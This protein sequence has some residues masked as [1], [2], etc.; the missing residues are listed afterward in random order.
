MKIV[1]IVSEIGWAL[2]RLAVQRVSIIVAP[3]GASSIK[4]KEAGSS[5]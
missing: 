5:K 1:S 4:M 3:F 2:D